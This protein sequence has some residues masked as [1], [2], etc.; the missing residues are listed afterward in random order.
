MVQMAEGLS[1]AREFAWTQLGLE[2]LEG[3]E[4]EL[5]KLRVLRISLGPLLMLTIMIATALTYN[6]PVIGFNLSSK[7]YQGNSTEALSFDV[8][9]IQMGIRMDMHQDIPGVNTQDVDQYP[10]MAFYSTSPPSP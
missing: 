6:H 3:P 10:R 1:F 9:S 8:E 5:E 7:D 2:G 4:L